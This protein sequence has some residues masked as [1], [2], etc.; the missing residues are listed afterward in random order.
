MACG[1]CRALG[2]SCVPDATPK[3]HCVFACASVAPTSWCLQHCVPASRY[4]ARYALCAQEI[5]WALEEESEHWAAIVGVAMDKD[6][7]Q[8]REALDAMRRRQDKTKVA[9]DNLKTMLGKAKDI[10]H[11]NHLA[12]LAQEVSNGH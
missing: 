8:R 5:S 6:L 9:L 7:A 1:L 12:H 3:A 2:R 10:V 4:A 11:E